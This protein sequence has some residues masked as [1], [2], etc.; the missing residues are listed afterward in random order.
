MRGN[1]ICIFS[2][3]Q[4]ICICLSSGNFI[5]LLFIRTPTQ[6]SFFNQ[7]ISRIGTM[8]IYFKLDKFFINIMLI[9]SS[10]KSWFRTS[11]SSCNFKSLFL[12]CTPTQFLTSTSILPLAG[13]KN[14]YLKTPLPFR[15][16]AGGEVISIFHFQYTIVYQK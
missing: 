16:G 15:G 12:F 11:L 14:F 8:D 3:A 9:L 2:W 7:F 1:Q 6:F 13:G 4:N 5:S 10:R